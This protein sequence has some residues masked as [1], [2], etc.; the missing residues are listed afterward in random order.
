[1]QAKHTNQKSNYSP[2]P[3]EKYVKA[4]LKVNGKVN[5]LGNN[6]T[7]ER[8]KLKLHVS[9]DVHFSKAYL[10]YLTKKYLKKNSLRDWIRVVANEKD[11]YELRYFR[12]S[13]NDDED[14]DAE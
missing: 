14:D 7:F 13:S 3:Q 4:R 12:I 11:S 5:N 10:K 2:N 1:M 8:S 6:V 9:S